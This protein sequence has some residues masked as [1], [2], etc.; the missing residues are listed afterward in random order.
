M[1]QWSVNLEMRIIMIKAI[2]FTSKVVSLV[3]ASSLLVL[4][5]TVQ[6]ANDPPDLSGYWM[7][8]FGPIP[9]V[10]PA[11]DFEQALINELKPGTILLADS[12][13]KE[14]PPGDFGGLEV[15][16]A[17]KKLAESFDVEI[18]RSVSHTCRSPSII[19]S[20]QGPFPIE[21]FQGSELIVIKM[22][23]FDV[24]RIIFMNEDQHPDNWP[25]SLTGHSIGHWEDETLIVDTRYIQASTLLNNGLEHSEQLHLEERFRLSPDGSTL[26]ISQEFE[27]PQV[28]AGSA[29]RI[30]PLTKSDE[31]VYPYDC[32]P[33]YGASIQ[34]R[35]LK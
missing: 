1:V 24:V 28:F 10:R 9:P 27:D 32:D 11:S 22:E 30:M 13:L 6:A 25:H 7:I 5:N 14:F 12:G 4:V 2:S 17:A 26:L 35:E 18:Q 33:G 31:H 8:D 19:Y 23:Y 29:A 21:I 20:M 3:I 16:P 34:S 15:T